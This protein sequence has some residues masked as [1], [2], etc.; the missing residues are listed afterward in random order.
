[1]EAFASVFIF[2]HCLERAPQ[3]L[4]LSPKLDELGLGEIFQSYESG[5]RA[6]DTAQK[7]IELELDRLGVST[8]RCRSS[9]RGVLPQPKQ[10]W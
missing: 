3:C 6:F 2:D 4:E 10:R 1:V 8:P 5:A 9:D 7:F